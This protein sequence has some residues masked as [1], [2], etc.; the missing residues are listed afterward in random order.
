[1][2]KYNVHAGHNFH[3]PGAS[4]CFSETVEDRNVKNKVIE[5]LR[6]QGHTV[7]D[8]TDED[9][10]TQGVNL[11]NIVRNCNEHTVDLDI[12]IHFNASNGAGHGVEVLR[13][14]SKCDEVASR[15]CSKISSLGFKNRGVKDGTK[16]YVL[17]HTKNKAILIECCF[18]DSKEDA[19]L[20]NSDSMAIAIVS[21]ILGKDLTMSYTDGLANEASKNGEWYYYRNG[22]ISNV[23]TVAQNKNGWWY[24]RDG[25]VDFSYT[26]LAQNEN[27]WWYIKNGKVD[28]T[29]NG[30]VQNQSGWWKVTN[31]KVDFGFNGI[32]QNENGVWVVNNGK[33]N[34]D[35]NGN[36]ACVFKGGKLQV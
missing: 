29:H 13:Y 4:G 33:V 11:A 9:G 23:T 2:A 7:Y 31:G 21:G 35:Y 19:Q 36:L 14:S 5:L 32:A 18:C 1:M 24:V 30:L 8:C 25:K 28:F 3:V 22:N 20:Y 17:K 6:R 16:L 10:R 12:S 34:F 15:I 26:G 27:G